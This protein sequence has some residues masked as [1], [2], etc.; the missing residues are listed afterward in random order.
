[1]ALAR[2]SSIPLELQYLASKNLAPSDLLALGQVSTHWRAFVLSDKR[3]VEWFA[4]IVSY[5][6][7]TLE[8]CLTRFNILD[9]VTPRQMVYLCLRESCAVCGGCASKLYLP[10]IKR[11]CEACL[12]GDDFTVLQYAPALAKYDLRE[13]DVQLTRLLT[14]EWINPN[15]TSKRPLKLVSESHVKEIAVRNYAGS[16]TLLNKVLEQKKAAARRTYTARSE[17][18]RSAVSA[19][20][21]LQ[22]KG[23]IEAAEAVVLTHT[24][25][26]IPK[27]FPTYPPILLPAKAVD[28]EVVCFAPRRMVEVGGEVVVDASE[29]NKDESEA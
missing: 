27:A 8:Q 14:L 2:L 3:W 26:K 13:R 11:V 10:H 28:R 15:R 5:S 12:Q 23:S 9:K 29:D 20:E 18:Y 24:G 19:R 25:R 7:E 17:D 1:M 16:E 21:A 6:N 22:E 4:A